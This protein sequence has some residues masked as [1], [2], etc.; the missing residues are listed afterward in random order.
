MPSANPTDP[1]PAGRLRRALRWLG[2]NLAVT[3]LLLLA[4]EGLASFAVAGR[5]IRPPP[6]ADEQ[7][8]VAERLHTEYDPLLGWINLPNV[9]VS[10]M[11]G[12]GRHLRINGQRFRGDDDVAH[13]PPPAHPRIVV[14]GDSFTFG[15]GVGNE[16]T[17]AEWIERLQP[18]IETV[19][20]AQG[21]YGLDQAYLWY[22]RDGRNL[23]HDL[24]ILAFIT[25]DY[26]R[27]GR[28]AFMGYGKPVL[29]VRDGELEV[30]NVPP[31]KRGWG[32]ATV[33]RFRAAINKLRVIDWISG[34]L[35]RR[36]AEIR[37][38]RQE[39]VKVV[40]YHLF[41]ELAQMQ[42]EDRRVGILVHLPVE[43]DADDADASAWRR[44]LAAEAQKNRWIFIDLVEEMR[45]LPREQVKAL[46]IRDDVGR[47]RGSKGHYNEAGNEFIAR[48][49][50]RKMREHPAIAERLHAP[51]RD[52][53]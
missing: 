28:D 26:R 42:A 39:E 52:H 9:V 20:M 38:L 50:L 25:E 47:F 44:W 6:A 4:I 36:L 22:T 51:H 13:V 45:Q 41:E 24:H 5:E 10:N 19:N 11:Y 33:V 34:H 29:E 7:Q 18:G 23:P 2:I 53:P 37:Q 17:W 15:Y 49:L 12:E 43:K 30:D 32:G 35:D 14:S 8:K 46:F 40:A 3:A 21:G 16:Q 27:M 48:A 1:A 31:P